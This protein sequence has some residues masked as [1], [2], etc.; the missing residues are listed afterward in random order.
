MCNRSCYGIY[1][2]NISFSSAITPNYVFNLKTH[3]YERIIK[4][5]ANLYNLEMAVLV[6][7]STTSIFGDV[8]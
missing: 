8:T 4:L 1:N 2:L 5:S 3:F 6:F 7:H